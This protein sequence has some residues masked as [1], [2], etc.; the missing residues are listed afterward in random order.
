[1]A[2]RQPQSTVYLFKGVPCDREYQNT[3]YFE[4]KQEQW[5]YFRDNLN[6]TSFTNQYY[7]RY[8]KN[9]IR[10]QTNA[11]TIAGTDNWYEYNYMAFCNDG[12][13]NPLVGPSNTT[14][15][16]YCFITK[17]EYINE[18]TTQI[19][20]EIDVMQ[21]YMF[22]YRLG[23]CLV[24]REHTLTDYIGD[25]T[26]PEDIDIGELTVSDKWD[27]IFPNYT[28]NST[29]LVD[30]T[31]VVFYVPNKKYITT[32]NDTNHTWETADF[33]IDSPRG[34][35]INRI[36]QGC[37][38]IAVSVS[39]DSS[40]S[41]TLANE[42][43]DKLINTII[44]TGEGEIVNILQIPTA[45]WYHWLNNNAP[46][47]INRTQINGFPNYS[48]GKSYVAK[49]KKLLTYPY[50]RIVVS[51]NMGNTGEY[52]WEDFDMTSAYQE[53]HNTMYSSFKIEGIPIT[54]TEIICYPINHRGL[55]NDYEDSITLNDFPM[56]SWDEDSFSKWW[57][58][59]KSTYVTG[60]VSGAITG[61]ATVGMGAAMLSGN[62]P[63]S[64][65]TAAM[66][67]R[68]GSTTMA[69][70]FVSLAN[71]A[72]G[73]YGTYQDKKAIPDQMKGQFGN[74]TIRIKQNRLGYTFYNTTITYDN[75]KKL[76]DF[77]TMF[78]YA[79]KE[80]KVPNIEYA[81]KS[82]LRPHWNYIKNINTVI[83]P[84]STTPVRYVNEEV[85]SKLKEIYNN[86]I[87]FWMNGGEVGNYSLVN[88]PQ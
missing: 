53:S 79:I 26:V 88:S 70:G 50:Q 66:L 5:Q 12:S 37:L 62:A 49:N 18:N 6:G 42:K 63:A 46:Y 10:L 1:M 65:A 60:I 75:A 30:F 82:Q 14:Q 39:V 76:D 31:I 84:T 77:F 35:F 54:S 41:V 34:L 72:I 78:G 2:Y 4:D 69:H 8:E 80:T 29:E 7:Q 44:K 20:Y 28:S 64:A 38:Y 86:G 13:F 87:T 51:N 25:N 16:F 33:T 48:H 3:L 40:A 57:A 55:E 71:T 23:T 68:I 43:I 83:L 24:E 59:N 61:L 67:E 9:K 15:I 73:A 36:Y 45:L 56:P 32:W 74:N 81:S 52:K 58:S 27:F 85:E 11:S 17:I 47:S 22:E 21:T 19:S